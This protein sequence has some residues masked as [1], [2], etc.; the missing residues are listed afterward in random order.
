MNDEATKKI[1]EWAMGLESLAS[2]LLPELAQEIVTYGITKH[3]VYSLI[4][5][6]VVG[7]LIGMARRLYLHRNKR[8][9]ELEDVALPILIIIV[10]SIIPAACAIDSTTQFLEAWLTP[11]LYIL[12][13]VKG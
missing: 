2:E 6:C 11:K 10:L 12:K 5:W 7:V 1:I 9:M 4:F 3:A 8:E 13:M